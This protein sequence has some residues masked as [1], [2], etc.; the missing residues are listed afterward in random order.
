MSE[1]YVS[2]RKS[3]R[4][5][6]FYTINKKRIAI[7][8]GKNLFIRIRYSSDWYDYIRKTSVKI[9]PFEMKRF[10]KDLSE[11]RVKYQNWKHLKEPKKEQ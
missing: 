1:K 4:G 7:Q 11:I 8:F 2:L 3:S 10:L 5:I 6:K 9:K